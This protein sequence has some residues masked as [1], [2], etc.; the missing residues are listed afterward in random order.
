M[1]Y[2]Q[3]TKIEVI[4]GYMAVKRKCGGIG[5]PGA[6][7]PRM[8]WAQSLSQG[9]ETVREGENIIRRAHVSE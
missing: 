8:Y 3:N 2:N 1:V 7:Y 9:L 4:M 6:H 5:F